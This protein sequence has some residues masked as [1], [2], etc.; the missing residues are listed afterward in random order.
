MFTQPNGTT[1][2]RQP[3]AILV[4][5]LVAILF[6]VTACDEVAVSPKSIATEEVTFQEEDSYIQYLGK[7]YAGLNVTGQI[8]PFGDGDV[9]VIA[10]EGFSQYMRLY[11]QMQELPADGAVITYQD[12]GG[13]PQELNQSTWDDT[14]AFLAG[15]YSRIG[16][17][18]ANANIYITQAQ[19]DLLE[20]RGVS[21]ELREQIPGF[22]AEA[23]FLRAL[24]YYHAVDLFGG[25]PIVTEEDAGGTAAPPYPGNNRAE[26]RR[27]VFEFVESE[28]LAITGEGDT[29]EGQVLPDATDQEYGRASK[30]AAYMILAKLYLN[31]EV[32]TGTARYGDAAEYAQKVIDQGYDLEPTYQNLFLADND[33]ADGVVF[34]I[35]NDGQRTQHFGGTQFLTHAPVINS[36]MEPADFGVDTG[37]DGLR[38]QPETVELYEAGDQRPVFANAGGGQ[39]ITNGHS[40][41]VNDLLTPTDGY[42]VVKWQNVTSDGVDGQNPTFPD[43]DYPLFRLADAYLIYAEAYVRGGSN[44]SAST[45]VG[46]VNDIRERAGLG[47]DITQSDLTPGSES[48]LQFILDER[49]REFLWEGQRRSDLIRF[50]QFSGDAYVWSWKG[51][52]QNGT[53]INECRNLYPLP[54]GELAA[55]PNLPPNEEC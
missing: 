19:P 1:V 15:M 39:F 34:A 12:A 40:L 50:G 7:L 30:G 17:Q 4:L 21:P 43:T 5:A 53:S 14:N 11:W 36:T 54:A 33:Q 23:R 52:N 51:G 2:Y 42:G 28:L 26:A 29:P 46:Y 24:S 25:V 27:A 44:T 49:G 41:Q 48:A 13:A 22:I 32:Y 8:G 18:V 20:Q 45:A 31:A 35:P 10:D 16:F 47:R 55:N 37:Y 38:T 6:G 9:Q 3:R